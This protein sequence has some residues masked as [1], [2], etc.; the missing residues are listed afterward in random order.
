MRRETTSAFLGPRGSLSDTSTVK[1]ELSQKLPSTLAVLLC[2]ESI[3]LFKRKKT[4]GSAEK[5]KEEKKRKETEMMQNERSIREDGRERKLGRGWLGSNEKISS[6]PRRINDCLRRV[7]RRHQ[8]SRSSS[9]IVYLATSPPGCAPSWVAAPSL[10]HNN[11]VNLTPPNPIRRSCFS[12][13]SSAPLL[14]RRRQFAVHTKRVDNLKGKSSL[15]TQEGQGR[16]GQRAAL[17]FH[18]A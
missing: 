11:N 6:F 5:R 18:P 8:T 2:F 13:F 10:C 12:W 15:L 7:I 3:F 1:G 4:E 9:G 17:L 16:P 14:Y